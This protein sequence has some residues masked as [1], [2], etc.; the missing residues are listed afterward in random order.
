MIEGEIFDATALT[1]FIDKGEAVEVVKYETA[2]LFV[3]KVK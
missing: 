1:G 3:R 2:Q